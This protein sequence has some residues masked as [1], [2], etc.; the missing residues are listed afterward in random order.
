MDKQI[1]FAVRDTVTWLALRAERS[2][3][4]EPMKL[5]LG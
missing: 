2:D 1:D 3:I 4:P 5:N